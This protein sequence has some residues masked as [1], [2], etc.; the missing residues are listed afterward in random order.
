MAENSGEIIQANE[1]HAAELSDPKF[2]NIGLKRIEGLDTPVQEEKLQE[3]RKLLEDES[4]STLNDTSEIHKRGS[5]FNNTDP[6]YGLKRYVLELFHDLVSPRSSEVVII[7]PQDAISQKMV[8][9]I[10][11]S[12][13]SEERTISAQT[14]RE[15][16]Q[17]MN[18]QRLRGEHAP[19][20]QARPSGLSQ[21]LKDG[22][23]DLFH[24][25]RTPMPSDSVVIPERTKVSEAIVKASQQEHPEIGV[26]AIREVIQDSNQR[27]HEA[28]VSARRE[29]VKPLWKRLITRNNS[30]NAQRKSV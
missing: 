5:E 10:D 28:E 6:K 22:L 15:V 7:P 19:L 29:V 18:L 23:F 11:P 14:A 9:S 24:Y 2:A 16:L 30:S 20:V 4:T 3:V 17:S 8:E 26:K 1:I 12:R 21:R 27:K 25:L 13:T